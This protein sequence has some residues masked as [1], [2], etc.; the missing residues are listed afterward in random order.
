MNPDMCYR[1]AYMNLHVAGT[2]NKLNVDHRTS[3]M[4][5]AALYLILT[6]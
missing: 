2:V 5:G 6:N 3:N 4:D 1:G